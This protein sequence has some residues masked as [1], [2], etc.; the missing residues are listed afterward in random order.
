MT[1]RERLAEIEG[2]RQR[3]TDALDTGGDE[4]ALVGGDIDCL[5]VVLRAC[6]GA[7]EELAAYGVPEHIQRGIDTVFATLDRLA[8]GKDA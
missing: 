1:L 5:L 6:V 8:G 3:C 7:L 4:L 2:R